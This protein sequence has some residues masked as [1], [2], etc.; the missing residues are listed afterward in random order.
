LKE[1]DKITETA[2]VKLVQSLQDLT[3]S[4]EIIKLIFQKIGKDAISLD[5]FLNYVVIYYRV[6]KTIAFTDIC[7]IQTCKTLKKANIGDVL[8]MLEGPVKDEASGI[9]RIRAKALKGDAC[10]G[11]VTLSGNQGSDFLEK[12]KNP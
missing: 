12:T 4:T 8:E 9:T 3:V 2:F 1:E 5:G 6:T 11:W 7:E 10:E